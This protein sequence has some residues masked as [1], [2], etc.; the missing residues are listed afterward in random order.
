MSPYAQAKVLRA[1]ESKEI[2]RLGGRRSVPVNI[3]VIAA[4]NQDLK[5]LAAA[6]TFRKDL[7]FRLNVARLHLP[8]LRERQEDILSLLRY[9]IQ[10]ANRRF[11]RHVECFTPEALAHL[12]GYPWPGNVR[13][14]KNLVEVSFINLPASHTTHIELPDLFLRQCQEAAGIPQN[15]RDRLVHALYATQWNKSKTA[16]QL[17]WSRMTVY[18]K[19]AKY[20]IV[21]GGKGEG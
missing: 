2:L 15:E 8:P 4:T 12:L 18:R 6:G 10:D 20:H 7:Y 14:L 19:M 21:R 11:V 3:R 17:H 1:L 9:Y 13:E 16:A 5:Q